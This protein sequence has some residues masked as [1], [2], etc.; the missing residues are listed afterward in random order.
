VP[1]S[2][3]RVCV[4]VHYNIKLKQLVLVV[5]LFIIRESHIKID[6]SDDSNQSLTYMYVGT[7]NIYVPIYILV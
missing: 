4:F 1:L 7:F 5:L 3:I 2:K 6:S